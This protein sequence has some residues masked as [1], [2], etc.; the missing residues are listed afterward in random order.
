MPLS[1]QK[2]RSSGHYFFRRSASSR[3][4]L[5][6]FEPAHIFLGLA[7][8]C[9]CRCACAHTHI[10]T[11]IHTAQGGARTQTRKHLSL[12]SF[13]PPSLPPSLSI[14]SHVNTHSLILSPTL[15][16]ACMHTKCETHTLRAPCMAECYSPWI[17]AVEEKTFSVEGAIKAR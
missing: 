5:T 13:L 16:R 14:C 3:V 9:M 2:I 15:M 17:G 12:P 8:P 11:H 10:T 1:S 7:W 6:V 4:D